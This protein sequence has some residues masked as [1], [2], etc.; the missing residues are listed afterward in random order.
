[1]R[2]VST[3]ELK[4]KQGIKA[5]TLFIY[6]AMFLLFSPFAGIYSMKGMVG[7]TAIQ[8]KIGLDDLAM[9]KLLTEEIYSWHEGLVFTAHESGWYLLLGIMYKYFKLWGVIA[10]GA[11]FNY[12]TGCTALSYNKD[13]AHPFIILLAI[14]ATPFL[15]GYPDYNVRPSVTSLFAVCLL[16]VSFMKDWKPVTKACLFA[17]LCFFLGWFQGGMLPLFLVIFAVFIVIELIYRN[18]RD[19]LI[20]AAG[21]VA[22]FVLSLLNPMGIRC[23]TFGMVQSTATDIWAQVQ[24]WLPQEFTMVHAVLILLVFIGFMTNDKLRKF[25]KHTVTQLALLCMFFIMACVYNRFIYYYSVTFL[26]FAPEQFESLLKWFTE[27]VVKLKKPVKLELSDGFYKILAVVCV[28]MI[29]VH[30]YLYIPRYLPTG[31]FNDVEK[32]AAKDPEAVQF[33][34]DHGYERIFNSFDSGSWLVFH[35]VKVHIDNRIDP[36]LMEFSGEDYIRDQMQCST[37]A[38]LDVFRARYDCDAFLLDMQDG[39]SYLLYEVETYAP[40]RYRVVY[41]NVVES[42]IPDLGSTRYVI[43]ECI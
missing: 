20:L 26:L 30:G 24:E 3:L 6:A 17:G 14:V 40:D 32:L 2:E 18:F 12:A 36:Y 21:L 11:I 7:D 41:D 9:G 43:I 5:T 1:M 39:F 8:I 35:G 33:I 25:E 31:T 29:G 27:V 4:K 19:S 13:K 10:V 23:Y 42:V 34:I 16:I 15:N 28:L 38:E 22:G 37:I